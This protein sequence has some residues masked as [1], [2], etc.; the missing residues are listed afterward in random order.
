MKT[1]LKSTI[2]AA[3]LVVLLLASCKS[4][5]KFAAEW[6]ELNKKIQGTEGEE[7]EKLSEQAAKLEAEIKNRYQDD[8]KSMDIIYNLTDECD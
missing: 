8:E 2:S 7:K 4:P 5:E 3:S 1:S 6:C